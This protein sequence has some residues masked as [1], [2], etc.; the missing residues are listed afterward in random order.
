M[1]QETLG[2]WHAID[3]FFGL[4]YLSR[5]LTDEYPAADIAATGQP[6]IVKQLSAADAQQLLV[7]LQHVRRYM[8]YC[9]GL[10]HH[11]PDMQRKHWQEHLGLGECLL[12]ALNACQVLPSSKPVW[13]GYCDG[14]IQ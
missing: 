10:R 2:R 1:Y 4:A 14:T 11:K 13:Q 12:S 8:L 3:L 6:I 7:Q 5:R 9:Q